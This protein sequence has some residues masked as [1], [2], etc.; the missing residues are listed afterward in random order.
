MREVP[1]PRV[2]L[3]PYEQV[4][5]DERTA[6]LRTGIGWLARTLGDN[7]IWNISS[8]AAG[9]GVA[10]L[11]TVLCPLAQTLGLDARWLAIDAD[12]PFHE[13]AKRVVARVYGIAGDGGP[14]GH[15]ELGQYQRTINSNASRLGELIRPGDVVI[16]HDPQPAGLIETARD[17]GATVVWRCHIGSDQANEHTRDGWSFVRPFVKLADATVFSI[18]EHVPGWVPRPQIIQ[19]SIDPCGPKNMALR[20]E[21]V[22]SVLSAAGILAGGNQAPL[23]VPVPIGP[24]VRIQ[25]P[26]G[27]LREGPAPPA[28]AP[29]VVQVSR[30]DRLKDMAGVLHAFLASGVPGYLTLAGADL[31][32]VADDP[33]ATKLYEQCRRAW[34]ALPPADRHRCQL[35]CLPMTDLR[36]N[37]VM[38]NALQQ[39]A[40]VI[41]QKSLAEGFGLTAT[42]AMWKSRPLLA[43]AVGGLRD[44]VADEKTGLVLEDPTDLAAAAAGIRRLSTDRVLARRLGSAARQLVAERYLV[45]RQ[46]LAW[47]RVLESLV[48]AR[49]A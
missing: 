1:L 3:A 48:R 49:A 15:A 47:A 38:V 41:V 46:L 8:T 16:V 7:S 39:H 30:W 22:I 5:G 10:E 20:E 11:L 12:A 4:L 29:M 44:Q 31:T 19:P 26:A 33:E 13:V 43:S 40:T 28:D 45:D 21:Q 42:E 2:S 14:L 32:G 35:L 23:T 9:G 27:V 25:R 37:A 6:Q 18:P 17:R 24:A 34:A 36:E